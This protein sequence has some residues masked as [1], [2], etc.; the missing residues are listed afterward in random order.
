MGFI[1]NRENLCILNDVL[2]TII[3]T[4]I[5]FFGIY[6]AISIAKLNISTEE[7]SLVINAIMVLTPLSGVGVA[8][9][10]KVTR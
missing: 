9:S 1:M 10:N 8:F 7:K 4:G 5:V 2:T 3:G 6:S